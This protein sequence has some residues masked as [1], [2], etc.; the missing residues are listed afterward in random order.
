M[1]SF[2]EYKQMHDAMVNR[3]FVLILSVVFLVLISACHLFKPELRDPPREIIPE[4]Y[5]IFSTKAEPATKWWEDFGS[6]E[7]NALLGTAFSDNLTLKEAWTRLKQTRFLSEKA[8][9]AFYP[10]LNG[11]ATGLHG[12]KKISSDTTDS[13]SSF[14]DYTI[15]LT[16]NYEVDLWGR[17]RSEYQARAL[18]AEATKEEL[19]AAAIT[20]SAEITR[21]WIRIISQRM[22]KQLLQ[23]QLDNNRIILDLIQFRFQRGMVS[24][25]DVFQQKQVVENIMAEIPLVEETEQLLIH[26]LA[27]LLGK[28]SISSVEIQQQT[29]PDFPKIPG[30]GLPADLLQMRPDIRAAGLRLQAADWQVAAARANR[31]P[32]IRLTASAQYG[33]AEMDALL[34]NWLLSLAAGL[35]APIFNGGQRKAE[36]ERT[37]AVADENVIHYKRTVLAAIKEVEDALVRERKQKEHILA[38]ERVYA[39]ADSTFNEAIGRYRNGLNDYLPVLTQLLLVQSLERNLIQRRT[40]LLEAR[41]AMYR[42]LGGTWVGNLQMEGLENNEIHQGNL[43]HDGKPE[44]Q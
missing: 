27:V 11:F 33:G 28:P 8:E 7:L 20:L 23:K 42:A 39:T 22:Q 9:S 43:N 4:R 38:L 30:I 6:E 13:T 21:N 44:I 2:F 19:Y 34:D 5:S 1:I 16:S 35:S 24:V 3:F 36:V 37:R 18:D 25:L 40:A 17:V 10:D 26:E 12:R 31:L 15:G 41:I 32:A 14:E 29:L